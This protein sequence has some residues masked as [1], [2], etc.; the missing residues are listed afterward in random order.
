MGLALTHRD[1]MH[2][3]ISSNH[4]MHKGPVELVFCLAVEQQSRNRK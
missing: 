1:V 3:H 2:G 4:R